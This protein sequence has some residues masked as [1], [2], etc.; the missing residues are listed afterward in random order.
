MKIIH[1]LAVAN[2]SHPTHIA[3]GTF[4]GIH[5]GHQQ[6]IGTMTET[7]H[8]AGHDAAVL[9]FDPRPGAMLG[10]S[11]VAALSTVQERAVL[12][13]ELQV[14]LLVVLRFTAAVAGTSAARFAASL[15][16]SLQMKELWAGPD[17]AL[18]HRRE[19]NVDYLQK[20]GRRMGFAM[21]V[22][23]PLRWKGKVVS[24]TRIR[25]ALTAGD[26]AEANGCLGRPY[27]LAGQVVYGRA[28]GRT[29]GVPTANLAPPAGRLIPA[30]GVY[31]CTA[32]T[33]RAGSWPA[34]TNVGV[35][36]TIADDELTVEAHLLDFN[37]DLYG[38]QLGLEF[39]A[40]L[41]DEQVF[42]S[43]NV[44]V[45]KMQEDIAQARQILAND[46]G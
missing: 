1:D 46:E 15:C 27:Y 24:S 21:R 10:R 44:L 11:P 16:Q 31:A 7:A 28:L 3:I 20:L 2:P 25:A 5:R 8:Q 14:D 6:L 40:R 17:F 34:V 19:G 26:V 42:P 22:V 35:R 45:A 36:P 29:L 32:R 39:V 37:G 38:Q 13:E 9:T 41:R 23:E 18:G 4:D 33:E 30:N 12:L 43:L